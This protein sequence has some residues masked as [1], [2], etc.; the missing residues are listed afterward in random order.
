V[1]EIHGADGLFVQV[2]PWPI[3]ALG[4]GDVQV[5][6]VV[7]GM[8]FSD[9]YTRQGLLRNLEPP[10]V[11]GTECAGEVTAVGEAVKHIKV[12]RTFTVLFVILYS[13]SQ[14]AF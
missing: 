10:L 6:V 1:W 3:R 8:N 14:C 5:S 2:K 9:L 7:C 12:S 13:V 11:L 4:A